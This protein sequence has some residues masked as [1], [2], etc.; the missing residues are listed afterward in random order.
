MKEEMN[1]YFEVWQKS[2]NSR[3]KITK[4]EAYKI[5]H[6]YRL[7]DERWKAEEICV[8][9]SDGKFYSLRKTTKELDVTE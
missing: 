4:E 5:L 3:K 8:K 7:K 9:R 1:Y 6:F 2:A